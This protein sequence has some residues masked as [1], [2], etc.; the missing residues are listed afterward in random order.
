MSS[1]E[2]RTINGID[3][4]PLYGLIGKWVGTRGVNVSPEVD[5]SSERHEYIDELEFKPAGHADN[6]EEQDLVALRYRHVVRKQSNGKIFHDQIGHWLYEAATGKVMH[7][8]SIP[9]GVCL[10]AG[11]EVTSAPDAIRFVVSAALGEPDYGIVQSP[12]MLEKAKTTA[13]DMTMTLAGDTLR[14]KESTQ[15]FIY[16]K[17]FDH[18]DES[19]L[20][21]IVYDD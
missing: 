18:T 5:G 9:R 21:R 20:Q 12:F 16:G 4:G 2:Y 6:A 7:S 19:E 11:G 1:S 8:L 10:L 13:F 17:N 14:Y 3:Y 15:L